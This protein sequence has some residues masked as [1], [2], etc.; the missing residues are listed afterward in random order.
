MGRSIQKNHVRW[1]LL[2]PLVASGFALSGCMSSPTYGTDKTATEQLFSD[3]SSIASFAP[4][5]REQIDYKP[6][7]ELVKPSKAEVAN[8]PAPQDN[9]AT[10][11]NP[12]WPESPEQRRARIRAEAT[13]NQDNPLYE[14]QVEMDGDVPRVTRVSK[15]RHNDP[16]K[17]TPEDAHRESLEGSGEIKRRLAESQQGDPTKRKYLSEPPI[18]YRQSATTAPSGELGEDEV[19]KERRLKKAARKKGTGG[20]ADLWPF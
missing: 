9:V 7:P 19:K 11:S 3:V 17:Y 8:L 15:P 12:S 1:A 18:T 4:P 10:S 16:N 20:F 14:P 6:R 5:K 2:S 13:A